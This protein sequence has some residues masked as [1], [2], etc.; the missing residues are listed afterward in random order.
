MSRQNFYKARKNY[1]KRKVDTKLILEFVNKERNLQSRLG[2]KKVLQLI[3][4]DL[5]DN[6]ISIGRDRFFDVLREKGMLIEK[7]KSAPKTTNSRH[8]LPVFYNLVKDVEISKPN[9]AWCSDL[10]YIRTDEDFMYAA[11]I[12]DMCSR[13]IVGA[14]IGDSLESIGCLRALEQALSDLPEGKTPIHHSDRGSQYCC[15]AY[16]NKLKSSGLAISMTEV[17]HCYENAMAERVNGILKQEYELD[18]TFKTKEQAR[19]AFYQAVNLY[20]T[21]RPHMSLGYRIPAEVHEKAA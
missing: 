18:Y 14:Y 11:L 4:N 15:H 2:G 8:N 20:N 10:T 16:Y 3:S 19:V 1:N 6:G 21:R 13:K 9:Q 5:K 7:K 17:N 12:T